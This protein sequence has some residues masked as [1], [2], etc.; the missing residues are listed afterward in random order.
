M[1]CGAV[2]TA[3]A[4]CAAAIVVAPL[5]AMPPLSAS[6]ADPSGCLAVHAGPAWLGRPERERFRATLAATVVHRSAVLIRTRSA[7][8][9][10]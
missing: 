10:T 2:L 5:A 6:T 1:A 4:V 9:A 8:A 3:G 7:T